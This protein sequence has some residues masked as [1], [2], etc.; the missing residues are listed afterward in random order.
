LLVSIAD[1]ALISWRPRPRE[2]ADFIIGQAAITAQGVDVAE[3][4]RIA[5][6][7]ISLPGANKAAMTAAAPQAPH[8]SPAKPPQNKLFTF[9]LSFHGL[10]IDLE[11]AFRRLS[12]WWGR[13]HGPL[14]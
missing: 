4:T 8:A 1:A 2:E 13:R 10:T 3:G 6:I 11:E 7:R 9:K 5:S 14:S 12:N